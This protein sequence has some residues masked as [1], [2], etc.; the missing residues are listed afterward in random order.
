MARPALLPGAG[1]ALWHLGHDA[2][3]F[4]PRPPA[5]QRTRV[6]E[7]LRFRGGALGQGGREHPCVPPARLKAVMEQYEDD[8]STRARVLSNSQVLAFI[9]YFNRTMAHP[10][11]W[12]SQGKPLHA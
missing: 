12:T 9:A 2:T 6:C 7:R 1:V 11:K 4:P 8:E 5:A 3:I 10:F